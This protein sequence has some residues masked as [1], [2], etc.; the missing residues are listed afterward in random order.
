MGQAVGAQRRSA[1]DAVTANL[2]PHTVS[3]LL[4]DESFSVEEVIENLATSVDELN[5]AEMINHAVAN[6]LLAPT[7]H[8][9]RSLQNGKTNVACSQLQ[10][11]IQLLQSQI[12][13]GKLGRPGT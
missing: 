10:G 5:A 9:S 2:L 6:A 3:V 7:G 4:G 12:D 13:A 1:P 11:F 8:V